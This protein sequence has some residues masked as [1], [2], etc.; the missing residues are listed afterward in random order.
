MVEYSEGYK[1]QAKKRLDELEK[2]L[3]PQAR[4]VAHSLE[5]DFVN[6]SDKQKGKNVFSR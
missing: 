4:A 2:S 1:K 3:T 5:K 6:S